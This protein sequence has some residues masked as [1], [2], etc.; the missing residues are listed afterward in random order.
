MPIYVVAT[1]G[2]AAVCIDRENAEV[3]ATGHCLYL[4][5]KISPSLGRNVVRLDFGFYRISDFFS[6]WNYLLKARG[7]WSN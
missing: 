2:R 3:S 1:T 6:K 4:R 5:Y 7:Y